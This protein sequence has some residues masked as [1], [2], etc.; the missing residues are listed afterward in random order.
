[1]AILKL[2]LRPFYDQHLSFIGAS[3]GLKTRLPAI[4]YSFFAEL[5]EPCHNFV[6]EAD[7][8]LQ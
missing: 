4:P 2:K 6:S 1:M 8:N 3:S 5:D 7:T